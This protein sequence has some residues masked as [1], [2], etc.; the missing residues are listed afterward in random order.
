MSGK[1]FEHVLA[2][3]SVYKFKSKARKF[4]FN[5]FEELIFNDQ[6]SDDNIFTF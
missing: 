3:L 6:L 2:F 1:L 4:I 5:L